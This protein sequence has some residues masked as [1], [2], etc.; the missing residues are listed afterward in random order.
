MSTIRSVAKRAV[1]TWMPSVGQAYRSLRDERAALAPAL[2]TPFGFKL[3]GNTS[4]A[5]GIFE[6]KEIDLFLK[7]LQRASTCVDIGANI[8][9]YTC[10]AASHGKHVVA[11]EPMPGNLKFLYRNLIRNDFG[12]VEVFP[13]ALSSSGGI[14]RIFG[15]GTAAS[16]LPGW[17]G[18]SEKSCKI[19]PATTL[20]VIVNTRFDGL[21]L[22]IKLDVEGSEFEVLKGGQRTLSLDPKPTWLVEISLNEHFP[23]GL[24]D[25]FYETF[26]VFWR[27]GYHATTADDD[28]RLVRPDDVSR[29][30]KQGSVDFGSYNYLFS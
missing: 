24:N 8:G 11:I 4:M 2:P 23:G 22:L 13:L 20:D 1:D 14:I 5:S 30:V 29:W 10:L 16:L 27:H 17:A 12:Y 18:V 15:D 25:R 26:E 7:H 28:Q 21:L 19:I 3:A 9:L 6:K